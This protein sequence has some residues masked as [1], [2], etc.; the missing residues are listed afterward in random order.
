MKQEKWAVQLT[1]TPYLS[2]KKLQQSS[3]AGFAK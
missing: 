1:G 3:D 2:F